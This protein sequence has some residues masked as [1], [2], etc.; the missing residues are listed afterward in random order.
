MPFRRTV[1]NIGRI[2]ILWVT[3]SWRNI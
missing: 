2:P 1:I 3:S